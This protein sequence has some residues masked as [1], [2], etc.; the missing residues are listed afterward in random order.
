[1]SENLRLALAEMY[2]MAAAI[3]GDSNLD[4]ELFDAHDDDLDVVADVFVS[5][6][7]KK[8]GVRCVVKCIQD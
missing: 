3:Y 1:M 8:E 7:K 4:L 6:Y 5:K 2:L